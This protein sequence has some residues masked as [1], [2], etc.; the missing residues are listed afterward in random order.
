MT[1]ANLARSAQSAAKWLDDHS[2]SITTLARV[3]YENQDPA[4]LRG[5]IS[6]K[7]RLQAEHVERLEAAAGKTDKVGTE[8]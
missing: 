3:R 2:V 5:L 8:V 6:A 7:E 4:F 1:L